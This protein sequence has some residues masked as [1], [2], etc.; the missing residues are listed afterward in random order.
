MIAG[1]PC[2]AF[3][4]AGKKGGFEDTRG[5]LF[6]EIARILKEKKPWA[7]LLENV[8]GLTHHDKGRTLRTILSVLR[9]ELNYYVPPP[10]VLNAKD[11]GLPQ[12]RERI[13]IVG[14]RDFEQFSRFEY[15]TPP[16]INTAKLADILEQNPVSAKYYLSE[17]YL[18]TLKKH[19]SRHESKG[20]GFGYEI[21]PENGI[22]NT[23]VLGGMG[24]ERNLVIDRRL[25]DRTLTTNKTGELNREFVRT[26]TPREWARL[27]GYPDTFKIA[28]A[29]SS[30]YR[31]FANS[32]PLNVVRAVGQSLLAA[33]TNDFKSE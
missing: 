2:Q 3:S 9:N 32:V 21:I 24:R 28:V 14:F 17:R 10:Q 6:F 11:F 1:F 31:Q 25:V 30:A 20:N 23:I 19:R 22:A 33:L 13:F 27:Q 26:M 5:T 29:D 16:A 15:P 7:F 4:I 12:K 8:K 18:E